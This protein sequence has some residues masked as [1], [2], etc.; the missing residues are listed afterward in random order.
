MSDSQVSLGQAL[1][2]ATSKAPARRMAPLARS[3]LT[4]HAAGWIVP[5]LLLLAWQ[6]SA[7][8]GLLP[9]NVL[10]ARAT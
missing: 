5:I 6:V 1:A 7:R 10:A 8:A 3:L 4:S 9:A 2:P